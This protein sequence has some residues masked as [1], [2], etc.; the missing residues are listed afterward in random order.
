LNTFVSIM[1]PSYERADD[2]RRCLEYR[3]QKR[4]PPEEGVLV[5]SDD[6]AHRWQTITRVDVRSARSVDVHE[7]EVV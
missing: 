3:R 4:R 1:L 7:A 5:Q 6:D 2:L